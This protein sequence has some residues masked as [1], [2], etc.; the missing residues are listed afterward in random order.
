M[1]KVIIILVYLFITS[2]LLAFTNQNEEYIPWSP[3][4][5]SKPAWKILDELKP[6]ERENAL[7]EI[8]LIDTKS[9]KCTEHA[10]IVE[11]SWNEG[12]FSE[13]IELFQDFE[14]IHN[15]AIGIQWKE[16][17]ITS[18]K[19]AEDAQIG[20]RDDVYVVSLDVDNVTGNLLAACL[21]YDIST[22]Y[23]WSVNISTDGGYTWAE[24]FT[25]GAPAYYINDI[26]TTVLHNRFYVGH[27]ALPEQD[28]AR[29]RRFYTSDGTVDNTYGF[30]TVFDHN[31][32]I[33][34]IALTS[35]TDF[36]DNRIYYLAILDN[37]SLKY[38]WDDTTGTSWG[39]ID[40]GINNAARGL[41]A[42]TNE[43]YSNYFIWVSYIGTDDSLYVAARAPWN[44]FG[45]IDYATS[46]SNSVTSIGAYND[47]IM[48]VFTYSYG[49]DY[50]TKY[51][52]SY[53]N[54]TNWLFS[55]ISGVSNYSSLCDITARGGDGFGVSF[56]YWDTLTSTERGYYRWRNYVGGWSTPVE[57]ADNEP[58]VTVKP[59]IERIGSSIWGIAY[60]NWP[61]QNVYFDR[62]DW[63]SGIDEE[64]PDLDGKIA[65]LIG[66]NPN[67]FNQ[68]T[69]I[70]Y[71]L[72]NTEKVTLKIYD[73][74]GKL[75]KTLVEGYRGPGEHSIT[76]FGKDNNENQ[77]PSGVY[78]AKLS[79]G[80]FSDSKKMV[81]IK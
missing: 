79:V 26:S 4:K 25:W 57:I 34:D 20:N 56:Q 22:N 8:D 36:Y 80:N 29:V 49:T 62:S 47:T 3:K 37:D 23:D 51:W 61:E 75:I 7:I 72:A 50:Y 71:L 1:K 15:V 58:R 24:T 70:R 66:N 78:F 69:N 45:P 63:V 30:I 28:V 40:P 17:I 35:N 43:E 42:C 65:R 52:V 5:V 31:V 46:N 48:T 39:P 12:N 14:D 41:D 2:T 55:Y 21:Y 33:R 67:P 60:A 19:W 10:K 77:V 27:T 38:Y 16:P 13:A 9:E 59:S 64:T 73:V 81:M 44:N 68:N 54:G 74:S 6:Y 32:E 11:E 53:N 18:A 76:W